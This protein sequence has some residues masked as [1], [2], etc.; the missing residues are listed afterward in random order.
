MSYA[1][2]AEL[3]R[4][5]LT[6]LEE[7]SEDD[8]Q[9]SHYLAVATALIDNEL[10]YSFEATNTT[11]QIVYGDGTP[12]LKLPADYVSGA[13]VTAPSGYTVP[14]YVER[15]GYLITTDTYGVIYHGTP[16]SSLTLATLYSPGVWLAGVPYTIAATY[17]YGATVP[18]DIKQLCIEIAVMVRKY[19]AVGGSDVVAT[20][21][22]AVTVRSQLNPLQKAILAAHAVSGDVGVY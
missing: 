1:A 22:A 4:Y 9:L 2:V 8:T 15:D 19:A 11:P 7:T 6:Q 18:V 20:E 17:G 16:Y 3:K 14:T 10:G 13:V 21:T 5:A 12:Y